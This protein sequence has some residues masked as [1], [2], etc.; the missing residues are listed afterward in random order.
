MAAKLGEVPPST[1]K[2]W[3]AKQ[4][5]PDWRHDAILDAAKR[6]GIDLTRDELE[7]IEPDDLNDELGA[8]A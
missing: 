4:S 7:N 8:A 6:E 5:I 1:V 3:H 2:S